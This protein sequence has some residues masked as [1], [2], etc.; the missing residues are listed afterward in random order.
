MKAVILAGGMGTRLSEETTL[1]PKPMIEIGSMPILWHIMKLY[2][3]HDVHDFVICLGYK[4]YVIKEYFANYR[5]HASDVTLDL[6]KDAM[7]IHRS[8][9]EPWRITLIDTG[10]ET[11]TGGRLK[12]ALR[13]VQADDLFCF[14]YGDGLADIDI[15][16]L[17]KFHRDQGTIATVTAVQPPG[18]FGALEVEGTRVR[19]FSEKPRGDGGWINGGFFVLNSEVAGYLDGDETVWEN[20]PLEGL[21][22][23]G[24][25]AYYRHE[26]FWQP[27]D[28]LRDKRHLEELWDTGEAPWKTWE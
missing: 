14:T 11:Q 22:R 1:R 13:Y 25:L 20:E 6:E 7:E 28:T 5:L 23:D 2:S 16:A 26:G 12:R 10:E 3:A 18:R 4:G 27:M 9:A 8:T 15:S 19:G 17:V 21:A 24:Q